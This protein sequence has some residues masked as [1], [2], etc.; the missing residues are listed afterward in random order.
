MGQGIIEHARALGLELP[1][2]LD[3]PDAELTPEVI[4]DVLREVAGHYFPLLAPAGIA[5]GRSANP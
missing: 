1:P 2:Q 4:I 3:N 5:A